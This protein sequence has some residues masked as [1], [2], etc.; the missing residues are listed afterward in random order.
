MSAAAIVPI[1]TDEDLERALAEISLLLDASEGT[2]EFDTLQI[3]SILVYDYER[4]H[5]PVD[6]P[7]PV[8]AIKFRMEQ[9]GLTTS[10][11]EHILGARSKISEVLNRKRDLSITM[12]RQAH[13]ILGIPAE[14]LIQSS[15]RQKAK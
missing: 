5:H 11:L 12:V 9:Q 14:I 6:P 10:D 7:D 4:K 8:E 15:K 2:Q 3:L 1:R 13:K